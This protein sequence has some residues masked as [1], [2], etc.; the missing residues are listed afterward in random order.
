MNNL[1][2]IKKINKKVA[3]ELVN[4]IKSF[5]DANKIADV[6]TANINITLEQKQEVLEIENTEERLNKI[7]GH[8]VTEIDSFK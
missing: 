2:N 3:I 8:L 1:K 7:Y 5:S 6:I 4:N